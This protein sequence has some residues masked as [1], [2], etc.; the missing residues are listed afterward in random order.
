MMGLFGPNVEKLKAKKDVEG[1]IEALT[2]RDESVRTR[3][4]EALGDLG[5]GALRAVEPLAAALSDQSTPV[6]I[7]AA[8]ALGKIGDS[9]AVYRLAL[10]PRSIRMTALQALASM[11]RRGNPA[12]VDVLVREL[13]HPDPAVVGFASGALGEIGERAAGPVVAAVAEGNPKIDA[14]V[15]AALLAKF[16]GSGVQAL[17]DALRDDRHWARVRVVE[18][19]REIGS[20]AVQPLIAALEDKTSEVQESAA[21]ALGALADPRAVEPLVAALA[22]AG[23]RSAA[24]GALGDIG[25]PRAVDAVV[26]ALTD[27]KGWVRVVAAEALGKIG[28]PRAVDPLVHTMTDAGEG[29]PRAAAADAL[30][31]LGWTPQDDLQRGWWLVSRGEWAAAGE[32][33]TAAVEPLLVALGHGEPA[34]RRSVIRALGQIGGPRATEALVAA[35]NDKDV[36]GAANQAL[37][38][39]GWQPT[40]NAQRARQ[41]VFELETASYGQR[42]ELTPQLVQIGSAAVEPLEAALQSKD[43][44]V[45]KTAAHALSLIG[46]PRAVEPLMLLAA[47]EKRAIREGASPLATLLER[48]AA[49]VPE[50]ILRKLGSLRF[51]EWGV[52]WEPPEDLDPHCEL[53]RDWGVVSADSSRV[54]QLARQ[55]LIRRG[56]EA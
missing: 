43:R 20:P 51:R 42:D 44:E 25:D 9:H 28:D 39:M 41:L 8:E 55:E 6:G 7:A 30:E 31:H 36:R 52:T 56:L 37:Q 54:V 15:A 10:A 24:L 38:T 16:G 48:A 35:L 4:A 27:E 33:G 45:R 32:L 29:V 23:I 2:H 47:D 50:E 18:T 17:V 14:T 26:N 22:H 13:A 12:A 3:A 11:A 1:L 46:D 19:L 5:V 49:Q 40:D 21:E 34:V 53:T